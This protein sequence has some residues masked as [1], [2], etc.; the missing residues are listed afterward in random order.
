[1]TLRPATD[2]DLPALRDLIAE[3]VRGLSEGYYTPAQ[4]ES[5][6]RYVFGPDTGAIQSPFWSSRSVRRKPEPHGIVRLDLTRSRTRD[7]D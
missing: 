2:A 7:V 6:L 4:A 3:S 5:A 1:M